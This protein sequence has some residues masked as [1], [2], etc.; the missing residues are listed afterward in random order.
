MSSRC[1]EFLY[2]GRFHGFSNESDSDGNSC[3]VA[4][5]EKPDGTVDT[6]S[7]NCIQFTDI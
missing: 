2:S 5:V 1:R 6:P 3:V 7:V 4:I